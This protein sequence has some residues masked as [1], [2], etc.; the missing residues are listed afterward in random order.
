MR[1][2]SRRTASLTPDKRH[3][4]PCRV[5]SLL[6]YGQTTPCQTEVQQAG[7]VL[8]ENVVRP[9]LHRRVAAAPT[10]RISPGA[11]GRIPR[12]PLEAKY[13]PLPGLY[14]PPPRGQIG[15]A[16]CRGRGE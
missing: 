13:P 1:A 3:L 11:L 6:A 8:N 9:E 10:I 14:H 7:G 15:R 16:S 4:V 5:A 2:P 12:A